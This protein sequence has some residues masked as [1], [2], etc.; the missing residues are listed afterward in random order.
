VSQGQYDVEQVKN[1]QIY[2]ILTV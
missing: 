1:M 2:T